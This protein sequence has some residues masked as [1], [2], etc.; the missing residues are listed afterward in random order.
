MVIEVV[1]HILVMGSEVLEADS[2]V[3][4]VVEV[5]RVAGNFCRTLKKF[6]YGLTNRVVEV[7]CR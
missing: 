6:K 4:L 2:V 1:A 7:I 5:S 3:V